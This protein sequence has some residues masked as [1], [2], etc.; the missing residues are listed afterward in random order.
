MAAYIIS[1]VNVRDLAAYQDYAT[2]VPPLIRKHGGEYIVRG[3]AA[4][5]LEGEW[6]PYRLVVL[7]FPDMAAAKAFVNDPEYQP[8]KSLRHRIADTQMLAVE[9][10]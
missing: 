4:E 5:V 2:G 3:G 6:K 1:N 8:F 7:K 10:V 9:G